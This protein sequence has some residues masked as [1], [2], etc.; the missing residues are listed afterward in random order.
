MVLVQ[1]FW[2]S[3][4]YLSAEGLLLD[5]CWGQLGLVALEIHLKLLPGPLQLIAA[6]TK[7]QVSYLARELVQEKTPRD[8]A[9]RLTL[10]V[11]TLNGAIS[12]TAKGARSLTRCIVGKVM[13]NVANVG[14]S[15]RWLR[16]EVAA[17]TDLDI[18]G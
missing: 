7:L 8:L 11:K 15:G 13:A 3:S 9:R 14:S 12:G 17:Y 18:C 10:A 2:N 1:Q 5:L 16:R 6:E 4:L